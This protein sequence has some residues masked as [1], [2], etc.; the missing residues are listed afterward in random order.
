MR[1]NARGWPELVLQTVEFSSTELSLLGVLWL[2]AGA[3]KLVDMFGHDIPLTKKIVVVR[4]K[5][6]EAHKEMEN[7]TNTE[8]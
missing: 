8:K 7:I 4:G 3:S 5:C 2:L 1:D 6:E